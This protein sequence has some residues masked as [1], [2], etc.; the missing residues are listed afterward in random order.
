MFALSLY[1]TN[2]IGV[3][4]LCTYRA[5]IHQTLYYSRNLLIA[6]VFAMDASSRLQLTPSMGFSYIFTDKDEG[7]LYTRCASELQ[8]DG[9]RRVERLVMYLSN[10]KITLICGTLTCVKVLIV[11][12]SYTLRYYIV[13][14]IL[15][16]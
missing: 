1:A 3:R 7:T 16:P 11:L 8:F 5:C 12:Y 15:G 2:S 9:V 6:P 14:M 4:F 10:R 13:M